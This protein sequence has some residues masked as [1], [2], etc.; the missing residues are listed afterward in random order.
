MAANLF[1]L[2]IVRLDLARLSRL[3]RCLRPG[4]AGQA[5]QAE[6]SSELLPSVEDIAQVLEW[7]AGGGGVGRAAG[8]SGR[9]TVG[10]I[11]HLKA[12]GGAFV[13]VEDLRSGSGQLGACELTDGGYQF[14]EFG[15]V[16]H[17]VDVAA[18]FLDIGRKPSDLHSRYHYVERKG[19]VLL[20]AGH[21]AGK[22]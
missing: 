18:A 21:G 7:T 12:D 9:G 1:S 11:L 17:Q 20:V 8:V 13:A 4:T 10:G 15:G 14:L 3:P 22:F 19:A 16:K 6:Q 5:G 2:E